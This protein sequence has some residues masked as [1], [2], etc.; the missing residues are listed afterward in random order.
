[1][2][3]LFGLKEGNSRLI[4]SMPHSGI[5]LGPIQGKLTLDA[6]R[7]PDTDWHLPQLY[8]FLHALDV[9]L[10]SANYSRYVVDLNRDPSG[11]SLYPGQSVT[12]LCPT[13]L[14]DDQPLY[15]DGELPDGSE[16]SD[17][18]TRY[19]DP[20]HAEIQKQ[21]DR[22][23][24]LHSDVI[25]FD[26]HSI[27]SEVP[28]FF[29]GKLPDFNIGTNSG[30]SC[31]TD[32][33]TLAYNT[34]SRSARHSTVLNGRFKGGFITRKYG[35]PV[36]GVHSIQLEMSQALYMNEET[37]SYDTQKASVVQPLL[38]SMITQLMR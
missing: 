16:I 11:E 27:K 12:E 18:Q 25:L 29:E 10:I 3:D 4:V 31:Y 6:M 8:N 22:L 5:Q 20:Y 9:T 32:F 15:L 38:R 36:E 7:L 13:T 23:R 2:F 17:R 37:L 26:A 24:T 14:F 34:L 30:K 21:I 28:R 1:M 35:N 19:Y 33:E